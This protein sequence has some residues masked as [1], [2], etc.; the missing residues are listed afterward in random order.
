MRKWD[1][2]MYRNR[3]LGSQML[4]QMCKPARLI[5]GTVAIVN[6]G[7]RNPVY[8]GMGWTISRKPGKTCI[9]HA[10]GWQGFRSYY[11]RIPEAKLSVVVLAN[12]DTVDT[13]TIGKQILEIYEPS[14]RDGRSRA[15]SRIP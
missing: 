11:A 13:A 6:P 5:D 14:L 7:D 3:I 12:L 15:D 4:A 10:G 2:A 9:A 1:A 8:Y